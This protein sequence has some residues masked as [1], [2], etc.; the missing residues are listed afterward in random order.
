MRLHIDAKSPGSWCP[1]DLSVPGAILDAMAYQ[2]AQDLDELARSQ[3][4]VVSRRQALDSGLSRSAI[5]RRLKYRKWRQFY[6]GVYVTFTG[7]VTRETQLWAAVLYAGRGARLS[8]ETAAELDGLTDRRTRLIHVTI[9]AERRVRPTRDLV[10]HISASAEVRRFPRGVIPHTVVEETVLDLVHG[11]REF[12]E[13]CGWVTAAFS[14][15]LT[16][17]GLMRATMRGRKRLRGRRHLEDVVTAAAE[18]TRRRDRARDN[19]AT[20]RGGSSLQHDWRD[21]TRRSA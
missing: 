20:A 19:A 21:V 8:H 7:P 3:G 17:E 15:G 9:P 10:V 5:T 14:K 2:I 6:R 16:T 1:P 18:H 11:A 12:D 4:G 13:A